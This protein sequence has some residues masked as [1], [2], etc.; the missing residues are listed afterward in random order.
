MLESK[1][2]AHPQGLP[3]PLNEQNVTS[4]VTPFFLLHIQTNNWSKTETN[5]FL[6]NLRDN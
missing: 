3:H 4:K 2:G 6:K 5:Y 1:E